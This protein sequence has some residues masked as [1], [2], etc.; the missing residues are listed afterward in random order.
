MAFYYPKYGGQDWSAW[1]WSTPDDDNSGGNAPPGNTD[2]ARLTSLS[3]NVTLTEDAGTINVLYMVGYTGILNLASFSLNVDGQITCAGTITGSS[4]SEIQAIHN[5]V[6]TTG[7]TWNTNVGLVIDGPGDRSI[8]VNSVSLGTI[9]VELISTGTVTQVDNISCTSFTISTSSSLWEGGNNTMTVTNFTAT[10]GSIYNLLLTMQGS[11]NL[12]IASSFRQPDRLVC[13][14]N[15][16][17]VT[18]L[19]G[20]TWTH[21]M[22]VGSGELDISSYRL[23][24]VARP[25]EFG[26][27][28]FFSIGAGFVSA[29]TGYISL[30]D[31]PSVS[32]AGFSIPCPLVL[33]GWNGST[34]TMTGNLT[35]TDSKDLEVYGA[36]SAAKTTLN[37]ATFNLTCGGA[38]YLG[39]ASTADREA[40]LLLGS[41]THTIASIQRAH[42]DD[43]EN[44]INFGTSTTTL[45]GTLNGAGI[46]FTNT[47]GSIVG[48][49]LI[50]V[51][52]NATATLDAFTS[53]DGGNN[54]NVD[55]GVGASVIPVLMF[56]YRRRRV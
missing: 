40:T 16:D 33:E 24:I 47:S 15:A 23:I 43:T 8:T 9:A 11:G 31:Y 6:L 52:C 5:V 18:T 20:L 35:L 4:G 55:F 38:V 54:P 48:G 29:T 50:N 36:R 14:V 45:S 26:V 27:D 41:G 7:M 3:G 51:D 46:V 39:K 56:A 28:D 17:D 32:L 53:V 21:H 1:D 19:T 12:K 25:A 49:T 42:A 30:F 13:A 37:L 22:S 34:L 2:N 44:A 10:A